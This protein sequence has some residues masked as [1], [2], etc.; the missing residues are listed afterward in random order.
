MR[1]RLLINVML[2]LTVLLLYAQRR[3]SG[4]VT[5]TYGLPLPGATVLIKGSI[6]GVTTDIYGSFSLEVNDKDVLVISFIG[7]LSQE[8]EVGTRTVIDVSLTEDAADLDEVVVV[9]YSETQKR[10]FTGSLTAISGDVIAN[11]PQTSPISMMQGRS[12]GVL[13][14]DGSGRPGS[15]GAIVIRGVSTYGDDTNPLY[16]I[17]GTPS[18]NNVLNTLNPNDIESISILKDATA[19]S[20]Y[21]SRA[22]FGVVL[23]TTKRGRIQK[24]K[25]NLNSQY[26]FDDIENPNGFRMM[27]AR[28]YTDYY[29]EAYMQN[30][31]NPDDPNSGFYL[32]PNPEFDTDWNDLVTRTGKTQ[33]HELSANGGNENMQ[34][35]TSISYFDQEGIVE[36]TRFQRFTGRSNLNFIPH[37]KVEVNFNILGSYVTEDLQF[38]ADFDDLT[39]GGRSGI[40][41]GSF[42]IAPVENVFAGP[43]DVNGLGFNFSIPSNAQHNPVASL[44]INS[45]EAVRTRIFPTLSLSFEPIEKLRLKTTGSI[46][47][48]VNRRESFQSKFYLAETDNGLSELE[49]NIRN[50]IN[51]NIIG[52]YDWDVNEKHKI[53]PLVGFE[54]YQFR[55][56]D[57]FF[58]SRDFAFDLIDNVAAGG[59]QLPP[60]YDYDAYNLVSFFSRIN[61]EYNNKLF[62]DVSVRRD[63]SSR[64]GPDNRWGNF[65]AFGAGYRLIE[66]SFLQSQIVFDDLKLRASYGVVGSDNN[67][68]NFDW[69]QTY[70]A[71]G[72]FITPPDGGGTGVANPGSRPSE[73]G[74]NLLKWEESTK[75][76]LGLDFAVLNNLV[77]GTVEYYHNTTNDLVGV[78]IISQ[79]SGFDEIVD[80]IGEIKNSG[81]EI[82][83]SASVLRN[84]DFEWNSG[85]NI[86]FNDNEILQLN[87]SSDSDTAAFE[88]TVQI[89]GQPLGQWYLPQYAGV[90]IATGSSL[91]YTDT[92][93]LTFD[94]NNAL[95][96]VSGNTALNPDFYGS[97]SNTFSYKGI[98]LSMLIYI[99]YGYEIYRTNLQ[100]L[101]LPSGNNQAA[102]NLRRWRQ[103]GDITDVPKANDTGAQFNSTR[104]LEDGS[105]IRL[106]NVSLSYDLPK[107]LIGNWGF[108]TIRV[109][110]RAVN[111]LT[112]TKFRGFNPD[113]GSFE[114][115]GDYPLNRTITFGINASL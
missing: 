1:K 80:N 111:L 58:S 5:D 73:P 110:A 94:V 71:G 19:T 68:G 18:E 4:T 7:F 91:Y 48:R 31:E 103:A 25:F 84:G 76:N 93:E 77:R 26:G 115:N 64:F 11:I 41:S 74:N 23:I 39:P 12:P 96:T 75:F 106:R 35:F 34:F 92:G 114:T 30:G 62:L 57:E 40:F 72:Q 98:Q 104:W 109:S 33:L 97:F 16:V 6:T 46:D 107:S 112:F 66:E 13:V 67:I 3:V 70:G 36:D 53:S 37:E 100:D 14:E 105:Y 56:T 99:K 55:A 82:D 101:S 17:D 27:N 42:N 59:I 2:V 61:Y 47:H 89:V 108:E 50:D 28:E 45:N 95:T 9:A 54:T 8:I 81:V 60:G 43:D 49:N 69:R 102:S 85:L 29:R 90:D 52:T 15:Q 21:G 88:S 113:T 51:F 32:P 24:T 63:G 87:T 83:L 65:Y 20:L 38:G 44:A 86:T 10:K 79:T 22:A 78:R